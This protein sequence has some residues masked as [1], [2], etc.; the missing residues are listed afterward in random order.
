MVNKILFQGITP[1]THLAAVR[2]VLMI[3]DPQDIILSTAFMNQGGLLQIQDALRPVAAA[4]TIIA[5]IRNG[6]TSAQGLLTALEFGCTVFVVDTGS[7]DVIFHP[8]IY[9]SQSSTEARIVLGSANLTIGGLNSNIEASVVMA[10]DL[11]SKDNADLVSDIRSKI[12]GMRADYPQHVFQVTN[13]EGVALLLKTDRVVDESIV[14]A[15][16]PSGLSDNRD[17]DTIPKMKLKTRPIRHPIISPISKEIVATT[18]VSA[19]PAG[20]QLFLVWKSLPLTRRYLTIPNGPNTN[21]TGSMLFTKGAMADIDQ[22][23]YFRD[24]VFNDLDWHYD[25]ANSRKH[26]ER[27]EAQFRLIIRNI[28]YGV[29]TLRLSHNTRT[30]TKA[31]KQNN[32]MTQLHW[33][34]VRSLVARKDLLD[35]TMYLYRHKTEQNLFV[36]EID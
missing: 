22:R 6:I 31:Y 19:S 21:P 7:R 9:Y 14:T 13:A 26:L 32:S 36:L 4:T 20:D 18:P 25:T 10:L 28:D 12:S 16:R 2:D 15:P 5:G 8:K 3:N 1:E 23:H 27:A 35:R 17:L 34:K 24:H 11:N 33:G 29:F 30:D